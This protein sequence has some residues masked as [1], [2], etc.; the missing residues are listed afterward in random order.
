MKKLVITSNGKDLKENT[1]SMS[2]QLIRASQRLSLN[3]KR[4][5]S[6]CISLIDSQLEITDEQYKTTKYKLLALDFGRTF[7]IDEKH[8]YTYLE[9]ASISLLERV[10]RYKD[11]E[12]WV[13]FNWVDFVRYR[14]GYLEVAFGSVIKPFLH[15]LKREFTIYKLRNA[16][17]FKSVYTWRLYELLQS[18]KLKF[19]IQKLSSEMTDQHR[20]NYLNKIKKENNIDQA[21]AL[22]K[23]HDRDLKITEGRKLPNFYKLSIN[24]LREQLDIPNSY[25][26]YSIKKQCLATAIKEIKK[27]NQIEIT[28]QIYKTGK[29]VTSIK[30][31]WNTIQQIDFIEEMEREKLE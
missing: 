24:E 30:F 16:C 2:N 26:W 23:L 28:Y 19:F 11:T 7:G 15:N 9:Q 14:D 3:E 1:V 25:D 22:L 29:A 21:Q 20:I 13:G 17:A 18:Y 4:V 27:V 31:E 6:A 12:G 10:G 5:V 8:A